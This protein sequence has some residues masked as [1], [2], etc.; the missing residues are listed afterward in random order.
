MEFQDMSILKSI[1]SKLP[2]PTRLMVS[3]QCT[4]YLQELSNNNSNHNDYTRDVPLYDALSAGCMS[5]EADVWLYS[6]NLRVA[7]TDPGNSGPTIQDLYINPLIAL[8]D[9]HNP[10]GGS[11]NGVYPQNSS[12]SFVLL[13]DFK[14][15]GTTTWNAVYSALQP[16]RDA[17][18]LSYWD[19]SGFMS[20]PITFVASGNAPLAQAKSSTANPNHDMF[21]D[22]R[23]NESLDGYDTSNTYYSS[24]DFES[25]ITSSGSAP[26]SSSNQKT[27]TD[28]LDAGHAKGFLVR[29]WDLPSTSLWQ[30]L[31]DAGVDRLNVDDLEAVAGVDF[32]LS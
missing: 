11:S 21:M 17:G 8:L 12:Q 3:K 28:Q 15:D 24:A 32:H 31:V 29:Y 23:V 20:R 25:A 22:S 14:S 26:L 18:Y 19:A 27:L 4:S 30:E 16:L 1:T 7:H 13:I 6:G 2:P 9:A 5:V 10:K